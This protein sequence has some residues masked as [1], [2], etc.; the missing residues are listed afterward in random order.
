MISILIPASNE[1]HYIGPCLRAILASEGL[2]DAAPEVIVVAN[3]CRDQTVETARR[4]AAAFSDKGWTLQVLELAQGSKIAA[5]NRGDQAACYNLRAYIDADIRVSPSLIVGLVA[6]LDRPDPAYASGQVV[7]PRA[8]SFISRHYA[9]F[10][11]KLPFIARGVPG[12]GVFAVNAAGRARW[13]TFPDIISDDSFVRYQ[14]A[15]DEMHGVPATYSWPITEGFA[16]LVRVRRRQD[17]GLEEIR[18]GWPALAARMEP[19][20]PDAAEKLRLFLRDPLGFV[21]YAT[22]AVVV[23]T[24]LFRNKSGWHRG[25]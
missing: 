3:G 23:R 7:V 17:E 5:L 6:V 4:F 21:I 22:V 10:W 13:S 2:T 14:F 11:Q 19:T 9:Q 15:P 20:A 1:E 12:C 8:Q 18:Q 24:P 25:R 16:N